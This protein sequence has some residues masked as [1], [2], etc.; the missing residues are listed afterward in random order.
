MSKVLTKPTMRKPTG[1]RASLNLGAEINPNKARTEELLKKGMD[2][3]D[4][5]MSGQSNEFV[6]SRRHSGGE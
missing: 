2:V 3:I 4:G 6:Q 5:S 1:S